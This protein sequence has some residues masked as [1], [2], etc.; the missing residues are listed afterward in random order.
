MYY[1]HENAL[2]C[3]HCPQI[4]LQ[5]N[6]G[7]KCYT[8]ELISRNRVWCTVSEKWQLKRDLTD[9]VIATFV[10]CAPAVLVQARRTA[11]TRQLRVTVQS[12]ESRWTAVTSDHKHLCYQ[13]TK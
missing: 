7:T 5:A 6:S 11:P 4:I 12:G 3:D 9:P 13:F 8:V 10:R 1:S 2:T